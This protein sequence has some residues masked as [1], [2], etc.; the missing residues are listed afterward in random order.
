MSDERPPVSWDALAAE[1]AATREEAEQR[2]GPDPATW[3][4]VAAELAARVAERP[5]AGAEPAPVEEPAPLAPP[6]AAVPS[7]EP[8][9]GSEPG[10][11]PAPEPEPDL[12]P[13]ALRGGLEALLF[14]VDTPVDEVTL[15]GALRCPSTRCRSTTPAYCSRV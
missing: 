11:V 14:V 5:A 3:D 9:P 12:D 10:P 8:E 2:G 13:A 7:R 1:L 15:A 4:A 6:V